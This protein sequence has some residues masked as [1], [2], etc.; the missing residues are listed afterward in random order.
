MLVV[1]KLGLVATASLL[2]SGTAMAA[3]LM[4]P[5][6]PAAAMTSDWTGGY[7]GVGGDLLRVTPSG[8]N[9][10]ELNGV[11]GANLQSGM[12]LVGLEGWLGYSDDYS[13][14]F[15]QWYAGVKGRA[16]F[17]V[18]DSALIYGSLGYQAY[19]D[20][21]TY[22]Q[23]GVGVEFM[24]SDSTSLDVEYKHSIG[25]NNGQSLDQI[26]ASLLWHFK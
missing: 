16:G 24:V 26:G 15:S 20:G 3:D 10:A 14:S 8:D 1:S 4:A 23:A 13:I 19:G 2:W 9:V 7:V 18:N 21:N 22:Y 6:P 17:V 25:A 5:P 12:F 11:L